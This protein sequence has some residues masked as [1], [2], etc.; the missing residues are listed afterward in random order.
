MPKSVFTDAY[1]SFRATLIAARKDAGVSQIELADRLG[2][3]QSQIS[4]IE[5]GIRRVDVIEFYA[6]AKALKLDPTRLFDEVAKRLPDYV[7][8]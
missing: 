2:L 1:A 7:E 6:I 3:T 4:Q 5:R 8:I